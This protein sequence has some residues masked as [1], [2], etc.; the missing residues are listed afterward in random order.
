MTP[1]ARSVTTFALYLL[2]LGVVLL[3]AP[4]LL[5]QTFGIPPTSEVWIRVVGMLVIFLGVYYRTAAA[6]ELVSFFRVTVLVRLTVPIFFV[7]FVAAGWVRWPLLLFGA[8]DVVGAT[9]T[10]WALRRPTATA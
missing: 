1:T 5:L 9:W 7:I 3:V 4:N 6:A 8:I 2:L 10:W